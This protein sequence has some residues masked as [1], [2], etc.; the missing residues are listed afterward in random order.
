MSVRWPDNRTRR[1]MSRYVPH[2][3]MGQTGHLPR[4]LSLSVRWPTTLATVAM[5]A[6]S[7]ATA[8]STAGANVGDEMNGGE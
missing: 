3:P 6:W 4:V 5:S 1:D 8:I 2:V 7:T